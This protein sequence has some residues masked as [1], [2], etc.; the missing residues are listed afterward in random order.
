V[1]QQ[2][3][4]WASH[5]VPADCGNDWSQEAI[6]MAIQA[7]PSPTALMPEA[8]ALVE[9]D[10]QYKV[11]AGFTEIIP[12]ERLLQEMPNNLKISW[13]VVIPQ[14]NCHNRLILNL[15]KGVWT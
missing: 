13:L 7:G 2:L 4:E 11:K 1:F 9:E 15:S 5:G 14:K 3:H 12:A 6:M 8:K 10:L